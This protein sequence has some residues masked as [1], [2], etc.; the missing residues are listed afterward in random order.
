YDSIMEA[1]SLSHYTDFDAIVTIK[2]KSTAAAT[3]T[4]FYLLVDYQTCNR[5]S[6]CIPPNTYVVPMTFLGGKPLELTIKKNDG[7]EDTTTAVIQQ[8][9]D[10]THPV[11]AETPKSPTQSPT[12]GSVN[13]TSA[14]DLNKLADDSIWKFILAAIGFGLLALV[15]PCVFP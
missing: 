14:D 2:V 8:P 9:I 6:I 4:P 3:K 5:A 12:S 13:A 1:T 15:T 7:K 10:T 11:A